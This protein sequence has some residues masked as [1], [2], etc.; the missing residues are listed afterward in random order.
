[1]E[2]STSVGKFELVK[3]KAGARNRAMMEAEVKSGEIKWTKFMFILLPKMVTKHPF[4]PKPIDD[5]LDGLSIE[6]YDK[7]ADAGR[8]LVK[9]RTDTKKSE[10]PSSQADSQK[11]NG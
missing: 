4:E 2:V 7:L 11:T 8:K 9:G 5:V 3:P 10:K 1:M 6:D